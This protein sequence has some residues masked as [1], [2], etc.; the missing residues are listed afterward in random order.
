MNYLLVFIISFLLGGI[1]F[2][3]ILG[4]L[5]KHIDIR[6]MGSKN[7]GATNA[8]R[9]FGLK[10]GLLSLV[11]DMAKAIISVYIGKYLL[12]MNGAIFAMIIV[13]LSHM[14]SYILG[15]KGGKGVASAGGSLLIIDWRIFLVVV[16]IFIV[17]FL[18]TKIVSISSII[19]AASV[20]FVVLGFY[21]MSNP[22]MFIGL[23]F[24]VAMIIYKHKSN[25]IRL[26]NGEEKK[27][28]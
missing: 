9:S 17:V 11:G 7:A 15:F 23:T 14:Y 3:Y 19:A 2:S 25:I 8:Y 16:S 24:V 12:G 10:I 13:V 4:M 5:F 26:K 27:L 20:P 22:F 6:T 1:S 18:I 28:I 21:G